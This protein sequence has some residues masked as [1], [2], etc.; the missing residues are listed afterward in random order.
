[1]LAVAVAAVTFI[2]IAPPTEMIRRELIAQVKNATGRD[3]TI[4]GKASVTLFPKV[5]LRVGEVSLSAPPG[6]GGP[7]GAP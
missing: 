3:L 4:A 2:M 7:P 6:M 1:M 5:G